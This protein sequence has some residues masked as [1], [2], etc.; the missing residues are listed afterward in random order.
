MLLKSV[1]LAAV[2]AVAFGGAVEE[3]DPTS[4]PKMLKS[5]EVYITAFTAPWCGM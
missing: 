1:V 4:F 3:L 2:L 5:D